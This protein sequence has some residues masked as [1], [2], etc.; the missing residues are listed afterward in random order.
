MYS[1][2]Y[3]AV[4]FD[5]RHFHLPQDTG[6]TFE[7]S[8]FKE[9]PRRSHLWRREVSVSHFRDLS[10]QCTR[11]RGGERSGA[12]AQW[13]PGHIIICSWSVWSR[14]TSRERRTLEPRMEKATRRVWDRLMFSRPTGV[15][16]HLAFIAR[17]IACY[18]RPVLKFLTKD[19]VECGPLPNEPNWTSPPNGSSS[20]RPLQTPVTTGTGLRM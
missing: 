19:G 13:T 12:Y 16:R 15:S 6:L 8:Y 7:S 18:L 17:T 20:P 5:L 4:R 11:V 2:L 3:L 9:P 10:R 1:T 14:F